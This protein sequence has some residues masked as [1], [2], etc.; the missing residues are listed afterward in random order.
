V[1]GVSPAAGR[2]F[3][4]AD[5][6]RGGGPDGRVVVISHELSNR[7]FGSPAAAVGRTLKIDRARFTIVGV[8]PPDFCGLNVGAALDVI[9]PLETEPLL[10]R[11]SSRFERWPWLHIT[12][13]L[14]PRG[15]VGSA[16]AAMRAAQPQIRDATMPYTRAQDRDTYLRKPWTMRSAATGSS[17]LRG[18]YATALF[19]LLAIVGLVLLVACANIANLQL[20]RTAAPR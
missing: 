16:T 19:T 12:A 15:S 6:R 13:R 5:D 9:L 10:G 2:M 4:S 1:L 7:L 8:T 18:R 20:A 14:P 17:R 3:G 11:I